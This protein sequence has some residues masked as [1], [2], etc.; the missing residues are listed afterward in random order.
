MPNW[1]TQPKKFARKYF[2]F[3]PFCLQNWYL[4][5]TLICV[6]KY[7]K[8]CMLIFEHLRDFF[9]C[10][11]QFVTWAS[12]WSQFLSFQAFYLK[13]CSWGPQL[14]EVQREMGAFAETFK[15]VQIFRLW[16]RSQRTL[17]AQAV[18]VDRTD[19]PENSDQ[20]TFWHPSRGF[21][22]RTRPNRFGSAWMNCGAKLKRNSNFQK[23][24]KA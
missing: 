5:A 16:L 11:D 17:P 21:I 22:Q 2:P 1:S 3:I 19:Q 24:R 6:V 9:A 10:S 18:S 23:S 20:Q 7:M 13:I 8:P 4:C 12:C 15:K 14:D